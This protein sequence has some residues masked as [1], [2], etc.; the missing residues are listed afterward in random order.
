MAPLPP[1]PEPEAEPDEALLPEHLWG[2]DATPAADHAP[3][4]V[5]PTIAWTVLLISGV[6]LALVLLDAVKTV[7]VYLLLAL[8]FSFALEPA[9]NYFQRKRGWRRGPT[10]AA[11]I[12]VIFVSLGLMIL[13][14]VPSLL[15]GVAALAEALPAAI[16][17]VSSWLDS[18]FGITLDTS[19]LTSG[20][21][22]T[23]QSATASAASPVTA[24]FGFTVSLVGGIFAAFTVAMFVFYMVAEATQFRR[25]ILG[26]FDTPRQRELL[27]IW[28]TAIDKTGGYFYSRFLLALINGGLFF[29][30]LRLLEVPGAAPLAVFQGVVAAF[31]PIVGTYIACAVPIIMTW[32]TIGWRAA[33]IVL[34]YELI[35]QQVENYFIS[36][37]IQGRAMQLHPAVAFGAALA[38]GALGGILWAFL[39]LPFAATLQASASLWIQAHPVVET[40]MTATPERGTSAGGSGVVRKGVHIA[41]RWVRSTR[42]WLRHGDSSRPV[43]AGSDQPAP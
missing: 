39:A 9:V 41:G 3:A 31:I 17:S 23:A 21:E 5:R 27:T 38:G 11:L 29:I 10:T 14:F 28:E 33:L 19:S 30:V 2:H 18:S 8:F 7:V 43:P 20:A 16:E 34:I 32:L 40:P 12:A 24:L 13:I 4:W 36:P 42:G 26:L 35:Y 25:A 1:E 37:R 6:I 22:A 15:R